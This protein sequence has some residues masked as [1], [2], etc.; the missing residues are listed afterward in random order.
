MAGPAHF[1]ISEVA[2]DWQEPKVHWSVNIHYRSCPIITSGLPDIL[3][4][5]LKTFIK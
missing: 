2:V 5:F 4:W 1:T 3:S